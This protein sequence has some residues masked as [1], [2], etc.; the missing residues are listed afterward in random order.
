MQSALRLS[1]FVFA[2]G[3]FPHRVRNTGTFSGKQRS[4]A[5]KDW[6]KGSDAFDF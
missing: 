4:I 1:D 2:M 5:G 3:A 6:A